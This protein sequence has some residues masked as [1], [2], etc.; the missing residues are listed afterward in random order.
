VSCNSGK[1]RYDPVPKKCLH[2]NLNKTSMHKKG[3][4]ELYDTVFKKRIFL[5]KQKTMTIV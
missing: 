2:K 5:P 4:L 3:H 1:I